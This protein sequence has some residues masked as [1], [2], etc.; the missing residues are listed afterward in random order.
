MILR[1][2]ATLRGVAA[3]APHR[4]TR[5]QVGALVL[6]LLLLLPQI[7]RGPLPQ[8]VMITPLLCALLGQAW[9]IVGGYAGQISLG[10]SLFFGVVAY[11]STALLLWYHVSPWFGMVVG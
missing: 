9:N 2:Q 11:P 4:S 5:L 3:A 6:V 1:F 7:V 8:H 10:Q